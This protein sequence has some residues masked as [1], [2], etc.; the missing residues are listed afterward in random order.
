MVVISVCATTVIVLYYL[1]YNFVHMYR[2][3]SRYQLRPLVHNYSVQC[4]RVPKQLQEPGALAKFFTDKY[5][6]EPSIVVIGKKTHQV[7]IVMEK[8][9]NLIRKRDFC[10]DVFKD[11]GERPKLQ[12]MFCNS[13]KD[14]YDYFQ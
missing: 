4:S 11:T 13:Q 8:Y 1:H 14:A 3:R 5:C 2:L 10:T 6:M 7:E 9:E 12:Y